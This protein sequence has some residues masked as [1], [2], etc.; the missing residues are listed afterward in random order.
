[1]LDFTHIPNNKSNTQIFY[2]ISGSDSWQT[3]QKPRDAKMVH[4]LCI[5]GG[6]GGGGGRTQTTT[7]SGG[8]G[9]ASG[10]TTKLIIPAAL[11]PNIL[12]IQPG[13]G[14]IGGTSP[15]GN[16]NANA[17]LNGGNS[18]VSL[19]PSNSTSSIICAAPGGNGGKG[20]LL[21]GPAAGGTSTNA[22]TPTNAIF[23]S[24]G[25][26]SSEPTIAGKKAY[27]CLIT[28]YCNRRWWRWIGKLI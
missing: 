20:G 15:S 24:L 22:Y 5:G 13:V 2:A 16:V 14:G 7:L 25:N 27:I 1:M 11:V 23:M 10:G 17:G 21:S 19:S 26:Y 9:G 4:I 6:G 12:Y 8:G 3:W 28:K 18:I